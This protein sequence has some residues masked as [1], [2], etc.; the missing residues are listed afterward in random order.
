MLYSDLQ[1]IT[2][3]KEVQIMMVHV[4]I[5]GVEAGAASDRL[6]HVDTGI[7]KHILDHSNFNLSEV[8]VSVFDRSQER[9]SA[10]YIRICHDL[11]VHDHNYYPMVIKLIEIIRRYEKLYLYG[12]HIIQMNYAPPAPGGHLP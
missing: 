11:H 8:S 10:P 1:N 9:T 4:E 2:H 12:I 7:R 3:G 6:Q 5:H